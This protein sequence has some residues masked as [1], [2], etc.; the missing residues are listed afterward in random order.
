MKHHGCRSHIRDRDKLTGQEERF[1]LV[2]DSNDVILER[3]V[4]RPALLLIQSASLKKTKFQTSPCIWFPGDSSWWGGWCE[5]EPAA[6]HA[7]RV[8][9]SKDCR[10]QLE[11][12]GWLINLLAPTEQMPVFCLL[13]PHLN[14]S[15]KSHRLFKHLME[16]FFVLLEC[17][18][19][20]MVRHTL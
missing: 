15:I 3:V 6:S 5:P 4:W 1:D 14:W 17:I 13:V 18:N 8:S 11:S 10:F 7:R 9:A 2:V 19:I 16:F 12:Q 20:Y